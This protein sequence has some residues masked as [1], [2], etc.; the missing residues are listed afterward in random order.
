MSFMAFIAF[1]AGAAA[2]F[3]AAAFIAFLAFMAF[4][5]A[6]GMVKHKLRLKPKDYGFCRWCS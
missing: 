5:D 3:L 1:G 6:F 4:G 2:V